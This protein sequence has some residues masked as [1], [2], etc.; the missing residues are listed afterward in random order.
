VALGLVAPDHVY[1]YIRTGL[2]GRSYVVN[3]TA[4]DHSLKYGI[5]IR[6]VSCQN[7]KVIFDNYGEGN[8][9]NQS[10]ANPMRNILINNVWYWVTEKLLE[11]ITGNSYSVNEKDW[12]GK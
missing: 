3:V 12:T 6:G 1:S 7:G 9:V 4:K 10:W 2:S 11:D 8:G 5:V